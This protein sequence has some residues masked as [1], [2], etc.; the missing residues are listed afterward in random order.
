M[1]EI[2]EEEAAKAAERLKDRV[3][4]ALPQVVMKLMTHYEAHSDERFVTIRV[5]KDL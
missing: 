5:R 2:V 4:E 1:Q 3:K